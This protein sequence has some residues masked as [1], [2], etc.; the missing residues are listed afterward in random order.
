MTARVGL[1]RGSK[2]IVKVCIEC[3]R[4]V[5]V[6]PVLLPLPGLDKSNLQSTTVQSPAWIRSCNCFAETRISMIHACFAS[7]K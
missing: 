3:A 6:Q 5:P 7:S 2:V 4:D 1:Y